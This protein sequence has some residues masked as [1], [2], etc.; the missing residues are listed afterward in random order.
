[1]EHDADQAVPEGIRK[2]GIREPDDARILPGKRWMR[3]F[4]V[5]ELPQ[6]INILRSEMAIFGHR[7]LP[8]AEFDECKPQLQN[9][10]KQYK[11]GLLGDHAAWSKRDK[12][13]GHRRIEAYLRLRKKR[14]QA[15]LHSTIDF[16]MWAMRECLFFALKG[17]NE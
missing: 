14:E 16:H 1:M 12:L 9:L 13:D 10:M 2:H 17:K 8:I 15:G 3:R 7:P 11:P 5:D 4:C 6:V